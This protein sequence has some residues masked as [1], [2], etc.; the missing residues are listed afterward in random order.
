MEVIQ[1]TLPKL[2]LML[3]INWLLFIRLLMEMGEPR[4]C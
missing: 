3:I 4:D 2:P 1:I